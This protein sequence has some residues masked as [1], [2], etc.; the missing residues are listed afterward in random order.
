MYFFLDFRVN[1]I[2]ERDNSTICTFS[3][4]VRAKLGCFINFNAFSS[5]SIYIQL[6]LMHF[7]QNLEKDLVEKEEYRSILSGTSL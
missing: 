7:E 4:L 2:C 3:F 1:E 6:N 5:N